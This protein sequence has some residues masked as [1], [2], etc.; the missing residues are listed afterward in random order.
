VINEK[1]FA[2]HEFVWFVGEVEARNDPLK[3]G[4]VRVRCFGWHPS[5]REECPTNQLPW[6]G[7]VQPVTAP[8]A[9]SSGLTQGTW[10]FG[11]F[12][13]GKEAQR[14]MIM[15][16]IPGY[17]FDDNKQNGESELPRAARVEPDYPSP[18]SVLR[19]ESRIT[20]IGFDVSAASTWDEP[21]EPDDKEY[22]YVQTVSSEAG[23]IT[24][25]ILG[26]YETPDD[27][28]GPPE[29]QS[30]TARQVTYDC[31]GGYEERRAPSGDK[32]VK[33]VGDNYEI[34]AGSSF[35]N[36]KG[37][38]VMTVE[39][40][41]KHNISGDYEL[42]VAGNMY[43]AIGGTDDK[44][45]LGKGVYGY[46]QGRDSY[47]LFG[48]D[49]TTV[50]RGNIITAVAAGSVNMAIAAG[51]LTTTLGLG[52]ITTTLAAGNK[53]TTLSVGNDTLNIVAG[54]QSTTIGGAQ[55]M[56]VVGSQTTVV[57][58]TQSVTAGTA[59]LLYGGGSLSYGA[60]TIT[61]SGTIT[62]GSING[63][64]ITGSGTVSGSVVRQGIITLGSHKHAVTS[65][66]GV[67]GTPIP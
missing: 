44:F 59:T 40:S 35:V 50:A 8:P 29:P 11:F 10:V 56:T 33:V 58:A 21:E 57:G 4:R 16:L 51:N 66:P 49:I 31:V 15:G 45:V 61:T 30:F 52:N 20:D 48:G 39:G 47:I 36:I 32:I 1:G 14:P 60:G 67:T 9:P 54:A 6:A 25:T 34:V 2:G 7:T 23:F 42:N 13:D 28:V 3:L 62:G 12:M 55:T 17:R 41:V 37:D 24:E 19:R 5:D 53:T 65:A 43:T 27:F 26:P 38:V 22:P 46:G 18:Q 63:V 64:T